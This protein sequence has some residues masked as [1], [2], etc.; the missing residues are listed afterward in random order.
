M[1]RVLQVVD[2]LGVGGAEQV[3]VRLAQAVVRHRVELTVVTLRP[4]PGSVLEPELRATGARMVTFPVTSASAGIRAAPGPLLELVRFVKRGGFDLIHTHLNTADVVGA[5]AGLLTRVPVVST[6]HSVRR[7][8]PN[9][10][11]ERIRRLLLRHVT[12]EVIAVGESVAAVQRSQLGTRTPVTVVPNPAPATSHPDPVARARVRRELGIGDDQPVILAAGR[13]EPPKDHLLMIE[14]MEHVLRDRPD[15]VL[16]IAG[17]GTLASTLAARIE[18]L[19]RT[20]S[21]RLLGHRDDMQDLRSAADVFAS[22]SA[23]EGTPMSILE[24]MASGLP[25]VATDVGDCR[26]VMGA[27]GVVVEPGDAGALGAGLLEALVPAARGRLARAAQQRA[28]ERYGMDT[29]IS[30]ILV[31]YERAVAGSLP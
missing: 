8:A 23:W 14:A 4:Y 27:G 3:V 17:R 20:G 7:T 28:R 29:W 1:F 11:R 21:V 30:Q 5:V 16:L 6:Q 19:G 31:V 22:S 10:V 9:P 13:L 2:S 12:R 18:A 25:V 15:A 24:A 26:E